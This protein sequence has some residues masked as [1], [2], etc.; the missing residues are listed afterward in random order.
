[1]PLSRIPYLST[2]P[3]AVA[4]PVGGHRRVGSVLASASALLFPLPPTLRAQLLHDHRGAG[5][6]AER[7]LG[8][9]RQGCHRARYPAVY[10]KQKN[11]TS[12]MDDHGSHY[13]RLTNA[14]VPP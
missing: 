3:L 11:A 13:K 2:P 6:D 1:M 9:M 10:R 5:Q 14:V 4:P 8:P 7:S 12:G